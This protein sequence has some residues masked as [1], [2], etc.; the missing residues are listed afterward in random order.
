MLTINNKQYFITIINDCSYFI[1]IYLLENK[2]DV[3]DMFMV[4]V[5]KVE[6]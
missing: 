2:S 6:N 1:F 4:F 3:F 5:T